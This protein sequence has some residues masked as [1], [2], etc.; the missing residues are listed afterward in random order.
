MRNIIPNAFLRFA[1]SLNA[2]L[3]RANYFARYTINHA[4]KNLKNGL[5][6]INA[7]EGNVRDFR[8]KTHEELRL[9]RLNPQQGNENDSTEWF[10]SDQV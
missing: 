7:R 4:M 3:T 1:R 6:N 2:R 8:C 10:R 5:V 9:S